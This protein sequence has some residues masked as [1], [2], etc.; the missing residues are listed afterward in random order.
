MIQELAPYSRVSSPEP[1]KSL[2]QVTTKFVAFPDL[3]VQPHMQL[4]Q[5]FSSQIQA[6]S[7]SVAELKPVKR[8][9]VV[10]WQS[11]DG[12]MLVKGCWFPN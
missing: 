8:I 10:C 5:N 12:R 7:I 9:T 1:G 3:L 4:F 6:A 11:D 2:T